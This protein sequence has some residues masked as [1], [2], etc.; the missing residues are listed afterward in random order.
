MVSVNNEWNWLRPASDHVQQ[1]R[2]AT[3]P[4]LR[5]KRVADAPEPPTE[6][7]VAVGQ[8]LA[9]ND[10]LW[11]LLVVSIV[12]KH[13]YNPLVAALYATCTEARDA[14]RIVL[15]QWRGQLATLRDEV[16][17]KTITHSLRLE[18][19]IFDCL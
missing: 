2:M 12:G 5:R 11:P 9:N 18:S 3:S 8:M 10:D 4:S 14:L 6:A 7:Q 1:E 17:D 13:E 15:A 19:L 16:V